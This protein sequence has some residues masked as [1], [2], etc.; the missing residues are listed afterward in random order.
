MFLQDST[1]DLSHLIGEEAKRLARD[2]WR[3]YEDAAEEQRPWSNEAANGLEYYFGSHW[4]NKQQAELLA[5][6]QQ[7]I[8][9]EIMYQIV[10]Q[11]VGMLTARDPA[12]QATGRENSD[13]RMAAMW[14]ALHQWMWQHSRGSARFVDVIRDNYVQGRGVAYAY[15]DWDAD[16]GQGETLWKDLD[17][18]EVFPDPRSTDALWDDAARVQTRKLYTLSQIR[19]GWGDRIAALI[20]QYGNREYG[21]RWQQQKASHHGQIIHQQDINSQYGLEEEQYEIIETFTRVKVPH[22]RVYNPDSRKIE[23]LTEEEYGER[24]AED[25]FVFTRAGKDRLVTKPEEVAQLEELFA[26]VGAIFHITVGP[27]EVDENGELVEN[28]YPMMG[29]EE[30]DPN[31]IP[32]STTVLRPTTMGAL[33]DEGVLP[34]Y[35]FQMDR[36]KV[37]ASSG[38]MLLYAPRILKISYYPTVPFSNTTN[39]HPYP[40]SD[41]TRMRDLQDLVNKTT[42]LIL[43]W[44][45]TATNLKV[46]YP[47]NSIRDLDAVKQDWG[48]A[49]TAMIPYDVAYGIG[50]ATPGG[51]VV[52][53]PAPLPVGIFE[54][55]ERAIGLMERIAGIYATQEG[56]ET[57]SEENFRA[58][59]AKDEQA[60]RRMRHKLTGIHG[61]LQRLGQVMTEFAQA[62]YTTEKTIRITTV[63]GEHIEHRLNGIDYDD[64][65]QEATRVNDITEG[66]YDMMVVPGSTLDSNRWAMMDQ[67]LQLYDRQIVDQQAVISATDLPHGW[68]ILERTSIM[69]QMM[70]GAQQMEEQ[71]KEMKGDLQTWQRE[72]THADKKVEVEKFK[73]RLARLETKASG[74]VKEFG[75]MLDAERK[76]AAAE[77]KS[78]TKTAAAT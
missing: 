22:W 59:L 61:S 66:Y 70:Q 27:Q 73:T 36:I 10:E 21:Y 30:E 29:T 78:E 48:A 4:T 34:S 8:T 31:S 2:A 33:I 15:Q 38:V 11:A 50:G 16:F 55:R 53:H 26:Q 65:T 20:R 67:Y 23:V 7:P 72:A 51:I 76:V 24:R 25:A 45:A 3:H 69:K 14:T 58:L 77:A 68:E 60:T 63:Q 5:R 44:Q 35:E 1:E 52:V 37:Y 54:A 75:I 12:F 17:P 32:G 57:Q 47:E 28:Q 41:V 39:R 9:I 6:G 74:S 64:Y 56:A 18:K 40:T 42:S 49:G 62:T 13:V 71:I 19:K 43:A 46:F